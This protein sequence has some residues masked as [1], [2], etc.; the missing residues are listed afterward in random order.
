MTDFNQTM[1]I[2]HFDE[3]GY[4]YITMS[5]LE[6]RVRESASETTSPR[7]VMNKVFVEGCEMRRWT[8]DGRSV[9]L[10]SFDSE[11][12]AEQEW[13]EYTYEHDYSNDERFWD[14]YFCYESA[15]AAAADI[16]ELDV[17]VV[18]SIMHHH[19]IYR[20]AESKRV[21]ERLMARVE[22]LEAAANDRMTKNLRRAVY[23]CMWP[24]CYMYGTNAPGDNARLDVEHYFTESFRDKLNNLIKI[25]ATL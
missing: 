23:D 14:D 3:K 9:L 10:D 12:E 19:E 15:V 25:H 17:K 4:P 2:L 8:P 5:T 7:G 13:L 6:Y 24:R 11:E 20:Q 18:E 1:Y 21:A 16:M 22:K